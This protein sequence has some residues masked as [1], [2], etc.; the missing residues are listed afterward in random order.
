MGKVKLDMH[1]TSQFLHSGE[2]HYFRVRKSLW[3]DRLAQMRDMGLNTVSIYIPWNWHEPK[4][5]EVD[6]TGKIV[7]ERDLMGA[8]DAI[9]ASGLKCI[10]RPGP[11][12]T[13]EWR[14][15]AIPAWLWGLYPEVLT[16][17][18]EGKPSGIDRPYPAITYDHPIFR[19]TSQRWL[20]N[21][22]GPVVPYLASRGGPIIN[23]QLED[24]PSYWHLLD[25]PLQAD[26]NPVLVAPQGGCSR[27]ARLL[28][29]RYGTLD[30]L[31]ESQGTHFLSLEQI[32]PPRE[33]MTGRAEF[34]RF[35]DWLDFKLSRI[36]EYVAFLAGVVRSCGVDGSISVLYPYL[37]SFLA[38]KFADYVRERGLQLELTNEC[39]TALFVSSSLSEHKIGHIIST[40]ETYH[41]W[42]GDDLG[43]AVSMELQGS[44]A[45]FLTPNAMEILYAITIA[46][47]IKGINYYML[48]G[49]EN[50]PG[51]E[52]LTGREY[53]IWAAISPNGEERPHAAVIRKLDQIIRACEQ[54]IIDAQPLRDI[55]LGCYAPYES[56]ALVGGGGVMADAAA[57]MNYFFNPGANG[58]S[59]ALA[60]QSLL[61]LSSISY[62]CLDL[63]RTSQETLAQVRQLWVFSLDFM[64]L[65]V[66]EKLLRYVKTGGHL[67]LMPC[68]PFLDERMQPCDILMKSI[69]PNG[70][71]VSYWDTF[72][73]MQSFTPIEGCN[74]ESL[75]SMGKAS[76]FKLP[77]GANPVA[78]S[79]RDNLPCAFEYP[80]GQGLV[81]ILGFPLQYIPAASLDQR[82]FAIHIVEKTTTRRYASSSNRQLLAMEMAG[83]K[84][85]F[86]CLVN[87]VSIPAV[88]QV[89]YTIP[90]T[91]QAAQ[92]PLVLDALEISEQGARLLPISLP[93]DINV[94]L[95]YATWELTGRKVEESGICLKFATLCDSQGEVAL[96]GRL[97]NVSIGGG[98]M[99]AMS[100]VQG[101]LTVLVLHAHEKEIQ[102]YI[103]MI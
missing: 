46:R 67:V 45:A 20:E 82:D 8:L 43:P 76:S 62:G 9:V 63:E 78:F 28:L 24:E 52:N 49:G 64:A 29:E 85:A 6:L 38:V 98:E 19:D 32:E 58:L 99:K 15:G 2:F 47:G 22:F 95:Q 96:S 13:A 84:S 93:L 7:P 66:Q 72:S 97:E 70:S 80:I 1:H 3:H 39:Y 51:Y 86:V 34:I 23:V 102:L 79:Q 25:Q 101:D 69:F 21:L 33:E 14:D 68:I 71:P 55:W 16:L 77:E 54:E 36:D 103:N 4:P 91:G 73:M 60:L 18:A 35:R 42:R 17:N 100:K 30:N 74:G 31:N 37:R 75:I 53:D 40:H 87:P 56:A 26:Y 61:A 11:F 41:M 88:T 83:K 57:M 92:M 12:I 59:D 44:N 5:G 94:S 27:Y 65:S 89:S 48:V 50:A 90:E 81:T 10:F